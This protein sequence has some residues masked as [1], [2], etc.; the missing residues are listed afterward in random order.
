MLF[1]GFEP[2]SV[3]VRETSLIHLDWKLFNHCIEGRMAE[4]YTQFIN[5]DHNN[6]PDSIH[7]LACPNPEKFVAG[8]I[9]KKLEEY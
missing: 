9:H 8:G 4:V 5:G 6:S 7:D 1:W 2:G 3:V